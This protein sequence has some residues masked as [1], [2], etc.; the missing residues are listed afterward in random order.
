MNHLSSTTLKRLSSIISNTPPMTFLSRRW[1]VFSVVSIACPFIH[2]AS[3][4]AMSNPDAHPKYNINLDEIVELCPLLE[5]PTFSVLSGFQS[6]IPIDSAKSLTRLSIDPR[7]AILCR[8]ELDL[9][10]N[11]FEP[12][13]RLTDLTIPAFPAKTSGALIQSENPSFS[14]QH[15]SQR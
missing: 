8:L 6:L 13:A 2:P 12:F 11:P 10:T 7:A 5:N 3:R 9:N 1:Q 14:I 4:A 15:R